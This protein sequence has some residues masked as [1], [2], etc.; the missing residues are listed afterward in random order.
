MNATL[1]YFSIILKFIL[2]IFKK[3]YFPFVGIHAEINIYYNIVK[4]IATINLII[5]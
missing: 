1:Q 5:S 2:K 4:K 3:L